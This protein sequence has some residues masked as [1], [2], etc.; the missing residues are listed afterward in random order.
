LR[1]DFGDQAARPDAGGG[2]RVTRDQPAVDLAHNI[3][4]EPLD[5]SYV[6]GGGWP[7]DEAGQR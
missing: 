5:T 4:H 6:G 2:R 1:I 3:L 7:D